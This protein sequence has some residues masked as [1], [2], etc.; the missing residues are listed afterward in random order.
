MIPVLAALAC[1][2]LA[3]IL[4][5]AG[6]ALYGALLWLLDVANGRRLDRRGGGQ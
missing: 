4:G 2:A 6:A 3:A 1:V 5:T